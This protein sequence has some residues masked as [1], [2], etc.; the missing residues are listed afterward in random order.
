M[1]GFNITKLHQWLAL[2][3][4]P[5]CASPAPNAGRCAAGTGER[6]EGWFDFTPV[7][8]KTVE[9][10]SAPED[11]YIYWVGMCVVSPT[12]QILVQQQN[13]LRLMQN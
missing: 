7:A 10:K 4:C 9:I 13:W 2:V 6:S 12:L 5:A 1:G 3:A 11:E 8:G